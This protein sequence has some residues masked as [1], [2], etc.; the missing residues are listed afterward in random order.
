MIRLEGSEGAEELRQKLLENQQ[1]LSQLA[2][3]LKLRISGLHTF[4]QRVLYG[5]VLP[6]PEEQF[7][8]F[9]RYKFC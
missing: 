8:Q 7:W 2:T 4:G 5:K 9:V 3:Q 6:E 1:E